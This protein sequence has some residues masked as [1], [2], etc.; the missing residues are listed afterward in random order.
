MT[1][2]LKMFR[3]VSFFEGIERILSLEKSKSPIVREI[4]ESQAPNTFL[5]DSFEII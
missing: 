1:E 2:L 4:R 5:R 3:L